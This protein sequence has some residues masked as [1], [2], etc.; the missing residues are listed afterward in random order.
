MGI[1]ESSSQP[2][3]RQPCDQDWRSTAHAQWAYIRAVDG[4]GRIWCFFR[5]G[6][7]LVF[8]G[9]FQGALRCL[10]AAPG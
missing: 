3:L 5:T 8:V 10:S 1:S 7:A 2:K 4:D 6:C 9:S